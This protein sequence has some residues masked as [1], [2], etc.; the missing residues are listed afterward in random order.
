M[1]EV[2]PPEEQEPAAA[3]AAEHEDHDDHPHEHTA[4]GNVLKTRR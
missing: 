4:D 2:E 1:P 3:T